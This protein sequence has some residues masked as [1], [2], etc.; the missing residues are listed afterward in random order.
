M[1]DILMELIRAGW[2]DVPQPQIPRNWREL[3][4]PPP[5]RKRMAQTAHTP[6]PHRL[7]IPRPSFPR[8]AYLDGHGRIVEWR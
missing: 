1:A 5:Q 2:G 8:T 3:P 7:F 4:P 6:R